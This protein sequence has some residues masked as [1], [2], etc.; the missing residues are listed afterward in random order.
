MHNPCQVQYV[1][2]VFHSSTGSSRRDA[3][4]LSRLKIYQE[5]GP[6][7]DTR[8]VVVLRTEN[9]GIPNVPPCLFI[10]KD[11]GQCSRTFKLNATAF[12]SMSLTLSLNSEIGTTLRTNTKGVD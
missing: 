12:F 7:K 9:T 2:L 3:S 1:S 6:I 5:F 10:G 4:M 11:V 8:V